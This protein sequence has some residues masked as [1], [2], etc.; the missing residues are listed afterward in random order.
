MRKWA[1]VIVKSQQRKIVKQFR[2]HYMV[3]IQYYNDKQAKQCT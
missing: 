1:L 3:I 2:E